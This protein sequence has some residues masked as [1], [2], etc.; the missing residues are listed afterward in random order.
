MPRPIDR[1]IG[2]EG[3]LE[4]VDLDGGWPL[5]AAQQDARES[6]C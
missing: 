5:G 6:D 3:G 1:V 4:D 2:N